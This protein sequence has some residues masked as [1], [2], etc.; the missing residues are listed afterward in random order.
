MLQE[1]RS[2]EGYLNRYLSTDE[3]RL[4]SSIVLTLNV[5]HGSLLNIEVLNEDD[6]FLSLSSESISERQTSHFSFSGLLV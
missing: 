1:P 2:H 4:E 5:D 3:D 6:W